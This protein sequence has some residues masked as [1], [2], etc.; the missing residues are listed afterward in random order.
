MLALTPEALIAEASVNAIGGVNES[1]RARKVTRVTVTLTR[2]DGSTFEAACV[3]AP[4]VDD[5]GRVTH[6]V[7]VIRDITEELRLREQ[8]VRSERLRG[9]GGVL[10]GGPVG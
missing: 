5:A 10:S 2:K 7:V 4:I 6:F 1:I 3:A 8:L 9:V